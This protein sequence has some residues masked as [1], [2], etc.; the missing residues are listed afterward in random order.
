MAQGEKVSNVR[1]QAIVLLLQL[2]RRAID[3]GRS[4][5]RNHPLA[6]ASLER[7]REHFVNVTK[8]EE[9]PLEITLQGLAFDGEPVGSRVGQRDPLTMPLF[10]EGI[11][12][13]TFSA[14]PPPVERDAF[15][16]AWMNVVH[17]PQSSEALSTRCWELELE[18][19]R[20]VVLDTFSLSDDDDG[21][22][23]AKEAGAR[24]ELDALIS[25]MA[26][27]SSG[28][29]GAAGP[30]LLRVSSDDVS[31]L[32]S[33]LVRGVTGEKLA[34]QD[35]RVAKLHLSSTDLENLVVALTPREDA[36]PRAAR[37]LINAALSVEDAESLAYTRRLADV[38]A[39]LAER[40][41]FRAALDAYQALVAD[42]RVDQES[43]AAR[44]KL[45]QTLRPL[46]ISAAFLDPL[47][48]ALDAAEG[49]APEALDALKLLAPA[50][51][52]GFREQVAKL[53]HPNA[54]AAASGLMAEVAPAGAT[55]NINVADLNAASF[56]EFVKR[57]DGMHPAEATQLL[58]QG[59]EHEDVEVRRLAAGALNAT[60]AVRLPRG[61][62][63]AHLTEDDLDV[64]SRLL[65][66][67]VELEDPSAAPA[68][69]K[70]LARTDLA[71]DE[72]VRVYSALG[73][74]G[75]RAATTAL[76]AE[77]DKRQ[78]PDVT[79]ACIGALAVLGDPAAHKPLESLSHK[80]LAT[81]R[82]KAAAR[83]AL[84]RVGKG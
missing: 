68:L 20:L 42:A 60:L 74:L 69:G 38:F 7:F 58:R 28:S 43:G 47:L 84:S 76:L 83:A 82:V 21:A 71:D 22:D 70:L 72:R 56:G 26:S 52:A 73:K 59:L 11:R 31:L 37:A 62:L 14:N 40:G 9:L 53:T 65:K 75:G 77:L 36:I 64:R 1:K 6:T 44:A 25:A 27:E 18:S 80:L 32:R 79:V 41:S 8:D 57:L 15:F 34:Q 16:D 49:N 30:S 39:G 33:E 13:I 5:G 50:L 35:A 2:L 12:R 81:P 63:A 67:V 19:I 10:N 48:R 29:A 61:V 17:N 4:Y 54:R 24:Q 51:G 3:A 78:D 45:L 23:A 55:K 46:F 66:L